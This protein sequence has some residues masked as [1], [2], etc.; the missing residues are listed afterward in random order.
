VR[1]PKPLQDPVLYQ[2]A[3]WSRSRWSFRFFTYPFWLLGVVRS[4]SSGLVWH[5]LEILAL[6]TPPIVIGEWRMKRMGFRL[7]DEGIELVRPVHRTRIRWEEIERFDLIRDSGSRVGI[8]RRRHGRRPRIWMPIPTLRI[9][10]PMNS[11]GAQ[12]PNGLKTSTGERIADVMG[13]LNDQLAAHANPADPSRARFLPSLSHRRAYR[14]RG[15][16]WAGMA[17]ARAGVAHVE[18]GHSP[19]R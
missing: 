5:V 6:F 15:L 18:H 7:T 3:R 8:K 4:I 13:F 17:L 1:D 16:V 9:T 14:S 10:E 11:A 2:D 19:R 12:G